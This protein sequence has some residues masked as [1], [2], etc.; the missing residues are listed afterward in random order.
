MGKKKTRKDAEHIECHSTV[1]YQ[2]DT[3]NGLSSAQVYE[4]IQNGWTNK[5]VEPPTKTVREIIRGN[6]FTYFN[7]VFAVLAVLLIIAG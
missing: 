7:M 2:A 1:R 4:Y 3:R 5:P 6:L